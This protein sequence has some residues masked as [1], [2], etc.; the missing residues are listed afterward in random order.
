MSVDVTTLSF[1]EM[2]ELADRLERVGRSRLFAGQPR[3]ASD[4]RQG[5]RAIRFL[6]SRNGMA[7][8]PQSAYGKT[9]WP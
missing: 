1:N 5:A 2:A 3:L 4:L 9:P 7:V 8:Q 6:L